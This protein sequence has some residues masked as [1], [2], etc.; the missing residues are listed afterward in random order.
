MSSTRCAFLTQRLIAEKGFTAVCAEADW[1][2]AYRI[3]RYV[4]GV[5]GDGNTAL[6]SL[7]GFERFPTWM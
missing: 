4:R 1:P 7:I 6:D 5:T 2:D 3:N